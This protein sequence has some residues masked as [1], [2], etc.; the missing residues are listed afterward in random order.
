MHG[1][2]AHLGKWIHTRKESCEKKHLELSR[3]INFN[4]LTTRTVPYSLK[5]S[6]EPHAWL[7]LAHF[8]AIGIHSLPVEP[9]EPVSPVRVLVL[10]THHYTCTLVLHSW[11]ETSGF[12]SLSDLLF[13]YG[14]SRR[15]ECMVTP[16][17]KSA[18]TTDAA[19][20]LYRFSFGCLCRDRSINISI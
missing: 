17:S 3:C 8:S 10:D 19:S 2:S 7:G 12:Q 11:N 16:H 6:L 18:T 5:N 4:S 9:V 13:M 15:R 20:F 14:L 1:L